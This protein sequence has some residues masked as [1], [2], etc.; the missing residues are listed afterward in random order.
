MAG[1]RRGAG[2]RDRPLAADA[3]WKHLVKVGGI[4]TAVVGT[5]IL[6]AALEIGPGERS[7]A[8]PRQLGRPT[9]DALEPAVA[10]PIEAAV[11]EPGE[12]TAL[13]TLGERAE[14]DYERLLGERG[15]TLQ[16]MVACDPVNVRPVHDRLASDPSLYLIP[17]LHEDRACFRVAWGVFPDRD[18]AAAATRDVPAV[19]AAITAS[20]QP[21]PIDQVLE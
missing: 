20:P 5:L 4:V 18:A 15:W 16:F 3:D 17:K 13:E 1:K 10:E 12:P 19:L 7:A 8:P 21:L 2:S 9:P 14:A 6:G 11:T